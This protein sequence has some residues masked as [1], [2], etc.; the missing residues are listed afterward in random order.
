[1]EKCNHIYR[2]LDLDLHDSQVAA[3]ASST[4]TAQVRRYMHLRRCDGLAVAA[5]PRPHEPG[6]C[7]AADLQPD[8]LEQRV[9]DRVDV[10]DVGRARHRVCD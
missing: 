4:E 10:L 3:S 6:A 8:R 9:A 2:T 5:L 7:S 1:M